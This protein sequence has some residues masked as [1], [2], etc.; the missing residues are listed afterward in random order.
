[1]IGVTDT[2]SRR[3]GWHAAAVLVVGKGWQHRFTILRR[4]HTNPQRKKKGEAA[5]R[6]S[7]LCAKLESNMISMQQR[8]CIWR[9]TAAY[10]GPLGLKEGMIEQDL[11]D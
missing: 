7:L 8:E 11:V 5:P 1:M 10:V 4:P 2:G 9:Q 6:A 3:S